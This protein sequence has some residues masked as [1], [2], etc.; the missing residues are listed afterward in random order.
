M[1]VRFFFFNVNSVQLVQMNFYDSSFAIF[2]ANLILFRY[3]KNIRNFAR[4]TFLKI[5]RFSGARLLTI[6]FVL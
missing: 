5:F 2:Y 1:T 6:L 4:V 3:V